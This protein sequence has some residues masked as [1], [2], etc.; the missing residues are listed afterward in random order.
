MG[1]QQGMMGGVQ[2]PGGV[3]GIGGMQPGMA[4]MGGGIPGMQG[5]G[6]M[7]QPGQMG[8]ANIVQAKQQLQQ[9]LQTAQSQGWQ[10]SN[11]QLKQKLQMALQ[12]GGDGGMMQGM[13]PGMMGMPG[14]SPGQTVP[15]M[16]GIPG[17]NKMF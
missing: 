8:P 17:M 5:M 15:G 14:M 9:D 11:P 2:P 12:V 3:Q 16:G 4:G 1:M 13:Q 10:P 6:G 7:Q